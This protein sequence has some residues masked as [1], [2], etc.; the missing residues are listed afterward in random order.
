MLGTSNSST[1]WGKGNTTPNLKR[2][3]NIKNKFVAVLLTFV[4]IFAFGAIESSQF[5]TANAHTPHPDTTSKPIVWMRGGVFGNNRPNYR[6]NERN[7]P[8][9]YIG[10]QRSHFVNNERDGPAVNI[11]YK[12]TDTSDFIKDRS[13]VGVTR[14]YSFAHNANTSWKGHSFE[15]KD[16]MIDEI[17]IDV[18]DYDDMGNLK[19]LA[20]RTG[21]AEGEV[22]SRLPRPIK[23]EILED[24]AYHIV[25]SAGAMAADSHFGSVN[26]DYDDNKVPGIHSTQFHDAPGGH[27]RCAAIYYKFEDDDVPSAKIVANTPDGT[28]GIVP[29][30]S[31]WQFKVELNILPARDITI[32]LTCDS[33]F[34]KSCWNLL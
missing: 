13:I 3:S 23:I 9:I 27:A 12:I 11:K 25:G 14:T 29:E 18:E 5:S 16:D 20:D 2:T 30:N 17:I 8:R 21:F 33:S 19:A 1:I 31:A 22:S 4:T 26:C 15:T 32:P 7:A 28:G 34:S 10:F 24:D 6:Q